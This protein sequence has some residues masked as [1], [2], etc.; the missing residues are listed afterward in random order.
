MNKFLLL[1]VTVFCLNS[2]SI[3]AQTQQ[4]PTNPSFFNLDELLNMDFN[5]LFQQLEG[6]MEST[7]SIWEQYVNPEMMDSTMQQLKSFNLGGSFDTIFNQLNLQFNDMGGISNI[8]DQFMN[9]FNNGNSLPF[10]RL[11]EPPML[12]EPSIIDPKLAP[13]KEE[14][15]KVDPTKV[16]E[17]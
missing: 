13:K 17:I 3:N 10:F 1:M 9:Q 16:S 15:I 7:R 4:Q 12:E 5:E 11:D 14:K 6:E 2:V 8:I